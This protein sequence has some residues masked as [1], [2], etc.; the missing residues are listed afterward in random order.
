MRSTLPVVKLD[1]PSEHF[2]RW[3]ARALEH[4]FLAGALES[5]LQIAHAR[6]RDFYLQ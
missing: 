5:F 1:S 4:F 6:V 2:F 3:L